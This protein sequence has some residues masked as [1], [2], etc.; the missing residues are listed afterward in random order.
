[1]ARKNWQTKRSCIPSFIVRLF[2][3]FVSFIMIA[4]FLL[5]LLLYIH[6]YICINI[7]KKR[8]RRKYYG[9]TEN[10]RLS[11]DVLQQNF[12]IF[13]AFNQPLINILFYYVNYV[14]NKW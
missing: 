4:Q 7:S 6:V 10:R 2:V 3:F 11:C 14:Y 9:L 8:K 13:A 12:F 1:M 5:F